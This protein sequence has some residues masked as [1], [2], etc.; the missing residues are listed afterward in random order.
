VLGSYVGIETG[1]GLDGSGI[2]LYTCIANKTTSEN[3]EGG[4]KLR[5]EYTVI[6]KPK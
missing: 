1:Y 4:G 6:R 5:I 3:A 2:K